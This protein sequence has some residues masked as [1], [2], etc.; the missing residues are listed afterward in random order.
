MFEPVQI[1]GLS[2]TNRLVMAPMTRSR[3]EADGTVTALTAEYYAQRSGAGLIISE[4]TQPNARGQGY[5]NT[6]GIHSAAQVESWRQVTGAVHRRQG[7]KIVMQLM[8]SGRIGHPSLYADGG[9]PVAPSPV[10]SGLQFFNGAELVE[11]PAPQELSRSDIAA[12]VQDFAQAARNA[13]DAGFDGVEVHGAN[14]YLVH[15]FLADNTNLRTDEYGGSIENR[16]RFA[17]EVTAAVAEAIGPERTGI[18]LSPGNTFNEIV[19]ADPEPLYTELLK[20]LAAQKIG[21]VHLFESGERELTRRL[22]GLWSSSL[23]LNPHRTPDAFPATSGAAVQALDE[24]LADAVS[25]ATLWL[26]NPDLDIRIQQ[27]GP[28]NAPD[29]DTFYG[30]DATGYTDYPALSASGA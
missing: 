29:P 1:G 5:I 25:L 10:A 27:D 4:G 19:E 26:A 28:F 11:Q 8:H 24:G 15:Q 13:I 14:G 7:G 16:I 2:L 22:R 20:R 30:G 21:F 23:I 18:R 17:L 12:T 9:L 3:A 6:P